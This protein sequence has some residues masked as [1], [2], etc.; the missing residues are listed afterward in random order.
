MVKHKNLWSQTVWIQMPDLLLIT[1]DNFN[2]VYINFKI[3]FISFNYNLRLC[4]LK[5]SL[6]QI[7]LMLCANFIFIIPLNS[8]M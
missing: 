4:V 2:Y 7:I 1:S 8:Y 6:L 3:A 5:T